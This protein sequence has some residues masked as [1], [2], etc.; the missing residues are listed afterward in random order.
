[1]ESLTFHSLDVLTLSWLVDGLLGV[2]DYICKLCDALLDIGLHVG[3]L[4][5]AMEGVSTHYEQALLKDTLRKMEMD[6]SA[7]R[8]ESL[9]IETPEQYQTMVA[10]FGLLPSR[11]LPP[12]VPF[13]VPFSAFVPCACKIAFNYLELLEGFLA[14]D[15]GN[16]IETSNI[17][18]LVTSGFDNLLKEGVIRPLK[19][20]LDGAASGISQTAQVCSFNFFNSRKWM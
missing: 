6:F 17:G 5:Q 3:P 1:M 14:G 20:F 11:S 10:T 9:T 18:Q 19:N 13:A 12:K 2:R 8:F 16:D 4:Q 15:T 7:D